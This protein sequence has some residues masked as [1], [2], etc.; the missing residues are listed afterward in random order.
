MKN[1]LQ[2]QIDEMTPEQAVSLMSQTMASV[3]GSRADHMFLVKAEEI[4][5]G[6]VNKAL[7]ADLSQPKAV[8]APVAPATAPAPVATPA[9][10]VAP[11]A[12]AS[13]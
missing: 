10:V 3:N 9:P 7:T 8:D 4:I 13:A 1:Q 2:Q 11:A 12:A 5:V 6:L